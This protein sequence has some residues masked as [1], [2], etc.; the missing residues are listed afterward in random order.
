MKLKKYSF[1]GY[2]FLIMKIKSV[3]T[4]IQFVITEYK[5][6][7]NSKKQL[8]IATKRLNVHGYIQMYIVLTTYTLIF[9]SKIHPN[10]NI[11]RN[12][13]KYIAV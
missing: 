11:K 10:Q 9:A 3:S 2:L 12:E 6:K 8:T 7:L 5:H 4:S 1:Q 13:D